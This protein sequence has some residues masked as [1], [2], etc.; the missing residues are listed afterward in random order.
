MTTPDRSEEKTC[1]ATYPGDRT[2]RSSGSVA[3]S[4]L[5]RPVTAGERLGM[6]GRC[7]AAFRSVASGRSCRTLGLH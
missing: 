5:N 3:R 4:Q 1:E 7:D 2:T 6:P